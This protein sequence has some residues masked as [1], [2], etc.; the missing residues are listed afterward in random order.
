[1][2]IFIDESTRILVQG[3]T[4][5][6]GQFW[7]HHMIGMGSHVVAGVTPGKEG[8]DF[9]G[10][11]VYH[12]VRNAVKA[13]EIDASILF[14]PPKFALDAV[15]EALDA[16]IRKLVVLAD[17]MPLHDA[18]SMRRSAL[19]KGAM[20]VG[21]NTTGIASPGKAMMGCFP[22]WMERV[23][24]PGR[25]GVM[26]RSGSLTNEIMAVIVKAGYGIS[27]FMGIGGDPVP[28]LRFAELLAMYEADE[29]TDA[30][31][32]IGEVG[33]SMEEEVAQAVKDGVFTKPVVAFISG[34]CAPK[35]KKMGHA[36]AIISNGTGSAEQKLKA[37]A[38]AGIPVADVPRLIGPLL[39]EKLNAQK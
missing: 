28:S 36:G 5:R 25:I 22:Y 19:E 32:I 3:I 27:T 2:S 6:E 13:H 12:S 21:P 38:E 14:V 30:L 35:D 9:E 29:Q 18:V 23:F 37:F 39:T 17:G 20:I 26:S 31:V 7:T 10:V 33:G 34:R 15:N 16:G 8:S 4:G 24:K 1:M 11:P